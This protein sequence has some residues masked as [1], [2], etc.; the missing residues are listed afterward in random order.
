MTVFTGKKFE[1]EAE[2]LGCDKTGLLQATSNTRQE[3]LTALHQLQPQGASNHTYAASGLL[4]KF[5]HLKA[6]LYFNNLV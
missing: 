5:T 3:L 4:C 2:V 1:Y 6:K